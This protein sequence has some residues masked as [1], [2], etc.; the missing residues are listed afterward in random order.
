MIRWVTD[1]LSTNPFRIRTFPV[2]VPYHCIYGCRVSKF[3]LRRRFTN[4]DNILHSS[5]YNGGNKLRKKKKYRD[6]NY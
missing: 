4:E 5:P 2:F 3:P 6:E 1:I